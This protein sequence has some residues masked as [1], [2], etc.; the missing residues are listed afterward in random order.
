MGY[1]PNFIAGQSVPV[2]G[3]MRSVRAQAL[4]AGALIDYQNYS[5]VFN[6]VRG[7]ATLAAHNVD[8]D[9]VHGITARVQNRFASPPVH[10][11]SRRSCVVM[12]SAWRRS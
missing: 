10:G 12:A 2:A 7:F 5:L 4:N 8:I 1:D 11:R 3:L 6:Q 9:I